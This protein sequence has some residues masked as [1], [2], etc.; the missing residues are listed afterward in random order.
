MD[1]KT[2]LVWPRASFS[3]E[4]VTAFSKVFA[5]LVPAHNDRIPFTYD[6]AYLIALPPLVLILMAGLA[7]MRNTFAIRLALLPLAV[8]LTASVCFGH[9]VS[10]PELATVNYFHGT[11][12]ACDQC[13]SHNL[14]LI[15][16]LRLLL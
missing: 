7:R 12:A 8:T 11:R 3:H 14:V 4:L 15:R 10:D 13:H 6:N 2:F 16:R 5:F 1:S 9:F